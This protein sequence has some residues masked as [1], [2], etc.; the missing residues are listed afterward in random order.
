MIETNRNFA[1]Y[2]DNT[3]IAAL[4][5][6]GL[7]TQTEWW[8]ATYNDHS[9]GKVARRLCSMLVMAA[10]AAFLKGAV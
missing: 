10:D 8:H 5:A 4:L 3:G 9:V 2:A 1:G 6:Q 7:I